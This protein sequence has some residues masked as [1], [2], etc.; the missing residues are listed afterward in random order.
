VIGVIPEHL[1]HKEV[2]HRGLEDLRTV[3]SMH[4]RKA[5][6][7]DLSDAFVALPGGY[8]TLDEFLRDLSWSQLGL[9]QK[10]SGILNLDGYYDGLLRLFDHGV[11]EASSA[12]S[13]AASSSWTTN[14]A[15]CSRNWRRPGCRLSRSGST[16]G[17]GELLEARARVRAAGRRAPRP[18]ERA[19]PRA[20]AGL[21]GR[22]VLVPAP[23]APCPR[24]PACRR[25]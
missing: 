22:A 6:M 18:P 11:R 13:I 24:F 14:R 15:G 10:P 20:G 5:L 23:R 25:G 19:A 1:V 8:G 9:H 16:A 12:R 21:R 7:A 3:S 4:E 17:R 2:A